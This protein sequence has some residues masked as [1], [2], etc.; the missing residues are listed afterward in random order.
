MKD[1][2]DEGEKMGEGNWNESDLWQREAGFSD[3][4]RTLNRILQ[5]RFRLQTIFRSEERRVFYMQCI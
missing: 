1:L 4:F 2:N 5:L 3:L